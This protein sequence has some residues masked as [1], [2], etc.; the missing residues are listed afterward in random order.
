M[1]DDLTNGRRQRSSGRVLLVLLALLLV[2]V[3]GG[4]AL[5]YLNGN[6][7]FRGIRPNVILIGIDTLRADA[8]GCY[9]APRN[10]SENID[11]FARA[12][13]LFE[14]ATSAAC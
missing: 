9:G 1:P 6:G 11:R 14:S 3:I 12:A 7:L 13:T 5:L 4:G 8:L 2:L 10:P